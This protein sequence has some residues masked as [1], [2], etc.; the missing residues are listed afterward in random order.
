MLDNNTVMVNGYCAECG[1][2]TTDGYLCYEQFGFPL[3]WEHNDPELYA[4]HFWL[5][6]CYMIQH[7]SNYTKEGY[8]QILNLFIDAY[9]NKWAPS[10]ILKINRERIKSI[11]KIT[12]SEPNSMRKRVLRNWT[13]TIQDIYLG[14]E[15][16]AIDRINDWKDAVRKDLIN[17]TL[18]DHK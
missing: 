7:P 8:N 6:A 10:Y 11:D 4:L 12:S 9:D 15:E 5:V 18:S 2:K 14:G 16:N 17:S 1:C 13:M 3:A